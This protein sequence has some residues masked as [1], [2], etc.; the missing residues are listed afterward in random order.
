MVGPPTEKSDFNPINPFATPTAED[1]FTSVGPAED[2]TE[3]RTLE[4]EI[5]FSYL[6]GLGELT[7]W[8][9]G[10]QLRSHSLCMLFICSRPMSSPCR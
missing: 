10:H 7:Y 5:G 9:C 6:Q 4:K 8:T 2:S 3:H 1:L